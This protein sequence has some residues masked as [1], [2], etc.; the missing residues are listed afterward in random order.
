MTTWDGKESGSDSELERELHS[1]QR[2]RAELQAKCDVLQDHVRQLEA[3]RRLRPALRSR[4]HER[5]DKAVYYSDM[6]SG[7]EHITLKCTKN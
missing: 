7:Q 1:L 5:G 6:D 4:S 3:E 2:E